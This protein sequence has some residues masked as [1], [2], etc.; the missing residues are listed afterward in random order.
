MQNLS[1]SAAQFD[2]VQKLFQFRKG[3]RYL[4]L[5]SSLTSRDHINS[6]GGDSCTVSFKFLYKP[7]YLKV[8]LRVVFR[9]ANGKGIGII[10]A[11]FI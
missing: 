2:R 3:V 1:F 6:S 4:L 11:V 9:E 7:E 8:G 5:L 10:T